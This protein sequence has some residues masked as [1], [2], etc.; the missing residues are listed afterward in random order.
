LVYIG[1]SSSVFDR[2]LY[3]NY[4]VIE[5]FLYSSSVSIDMVPPNVTLF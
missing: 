1:W 2:F 5:R 3:S 4:K